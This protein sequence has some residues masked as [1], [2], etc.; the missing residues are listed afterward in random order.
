MCVRC[1]PLQSKEVLTQ[2]FKKAVVLTS[3]NRKVIAGD[4][5]EF[6]FD[7]VFGE[8][9]EQEDI[10]GTCVENLID[11]CFS[12]YNATVFAY[13]QTGTLRNDES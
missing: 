10:Y 7:T 11:G 3:D 4:K 2:K 12:G 9:A 1:R 8:N 13:G 6:I 5:K